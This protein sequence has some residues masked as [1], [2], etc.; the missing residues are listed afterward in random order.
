MFHSARHHQ[1]DAQPASK[2]PEN[3]HLVLEDRK[4]EEDAAFFPCPFC[5]SDIELSV[6]CSHLQE[7]HCFD[8]QNAVC[9]ICAANLGKDV[10]GHFMMHHSHSMKRRKSFR[11]GF[12]MNSSGM[13]GKEM[14]GKSF[15]IDSSTTASRVNPNGCAPDPLLWPF[16]RTVLPEDSSNH[17][18]DKCSP[19]G[20][21]DTSDVKSTKRSMH[22]IR[23]EQDC[24]EKTLRAA[25]F[26]QLVFST[27][28]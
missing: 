20:S 17:I 13:P 3:N 18:Q 25:F 5:C 22:D 6:L 19:K 16:L 7:E 1:S 26:Q 23:N 12:R 2:N 27:I 21:S 9:P 28:S 15:F 8:F 4:G 11:S 14:G 10:I 24:E